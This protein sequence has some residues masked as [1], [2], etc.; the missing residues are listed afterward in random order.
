M[1]ISRIHEWQNQTHPS[2]ALVGIWNW[3]A[4]REDAAIV[5]TDYWVKKR[6]FRLKRRIVRVLVMGAIEELGPHE[7]FKFGKATPIIPF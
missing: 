5:I 7:V 3:E 4:N 1:S 6:S 2:G